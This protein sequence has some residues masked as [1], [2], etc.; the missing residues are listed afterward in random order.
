VSVWTTTTSE[1]AARALARRSAD[2]ALTVVGTRGLGG[3]RGLLLGSV[4]LRLARH[5]RGP[6]MV[7]RGRAA[8][9]LGPRGH[10]KVLVGVENDADGEAVLFAL[11]EAARRGARLRALH[12]VGR[13]RT[14]PPASVSGLRADRALRART[15]AAVARHVVAGLREKFPDVPVR[16]DAVR[17]RA[18]EALVHASRAADVVV[19]A[20]RP[21]DPGTD[22][23]LG[24][25]AHALLRRSHCPVVLVPTDPFAT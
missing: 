5:T 17:H 12:A 22:A 11:E 15:G 2:A 3:F 4:S 10:G 13:V 14:Q 25:V 7:V 1:D 20:V 23:R 24:P 21:S 16:C 19:V 8:K 18:A 6:L 9:V